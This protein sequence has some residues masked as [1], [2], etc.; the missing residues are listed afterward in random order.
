MKSI[1]A[2]DNTRVKQTISSVSLF[3]EVN[4]TEIEASVTLFA[5]VVLISQFHENDVFSIDR[6]PRM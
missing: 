3:A 6:D 1:E 2:N 5:F 4:I